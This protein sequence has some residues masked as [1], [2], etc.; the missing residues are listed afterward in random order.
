VHCYPRMISM[1][2]QAG[3]EAKPARL[4]QQGFPRTARRPILELYPK[5]RVAVPLRQTRDPEGLPDPKGFWPPSPKR[6]GRGDAYKRT[7][8]RQH[9]GT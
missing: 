6:P 8:V 3:P 7:G 2:R 4:H 9:G 5:V 1:R